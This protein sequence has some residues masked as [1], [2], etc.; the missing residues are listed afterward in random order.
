[1]RSIAI[2]GRFLSQPI[3]G[4]Q[5]YAF[6]LLRALDRLLLGGM[7]EAIP[8][9]VYVPPDT[10]NLPP[11]SVLNIRRV[12]HFTG[13]AWEQLDLSRCARGALLFTPCGGAPVMH[14]PHVVTIHDACAFAT[15]NAFTRTYGVYYRN[16]FRFIARSAAHVI[17]VSEFSRREIVKHLAIP[18]SKITCTYLSGEHI[19]RNT[20]DRGILEEHGLRENKFILAVGSKNPNKNLTGFAH[21]CRLLPKG[22][23]QVAIAGGTNPTIFGDVS[24]SS[25]TL[26]QLGFVNDSQLRSLYEHAA[27]FVFPSLYEGF[28]LPPLEAI[29]LGC[30]VVVS[31]SASLPEIFG[32]AAVYCNPHSPEDIAKQALRVLDGDH[33]DREFLVAHASKF[34]WERCARDTWSILLNAL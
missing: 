34:T 17:T 21:A 8:V 15:P 28:G 5:R 32:G 20:Q 3:T 19:L 30:P 31:N 4:V 10:T 11:F 14:K 25:D 16:L 2:N 13:Q 26:I 22:N 24:L 29:S 9:N 27:F 6:E 1:M 12:G 7:L 18:E 33:P 23:I